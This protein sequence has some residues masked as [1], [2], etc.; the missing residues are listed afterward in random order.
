MR[1]WA[2]EMIFARPQW[3]CYGPVLIVCQLEQVMFWA[4]VVSI[5]RTPTTAEGAKLVVLVTIVVGSVIGCDKDQ[6]DVLPLRS[7]SQPF[8]FAAAG[9]PSVKSIVRVPAL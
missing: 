5:E 6:R 9:V 4:A 1:A 2:D 3:L 8:H 7:T